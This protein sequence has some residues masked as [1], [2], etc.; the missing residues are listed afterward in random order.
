MPK[1]GAEALATKLNA[2]K[3]VGSA[4]ITA[5]CTVRDD[6]K[7][8]AD[9]KEKLQDC[10]L[11]NINN[12]IKDQLNCIIGPIKF[13]VMLKSVSATM[14]AAMGPMKT[15][16]TTAMP[17]ADQPGFIKTSVDGVE[18]VQK[19]TSGINGMLS[20]N[21]LNLL[22]AG[23]MAIFSL[24]F[25]LFVFG[26]LGIIINIKFKNKLTRFFTFHL[27][28]IV[29]WIV[30]LVA[31]ILAIVFFMVGVL[32]ADLCE[33]IRDSRMNKSDFDKYLMFAL[34]GDMETTIKPIFHTCLLGNG[35][36]VQGLSASVRSNIVN[37]T[38]KMDPLKKLV[39]NV[40]TIWA[41]SA[42]KCPS[43]G[44]TMMDSS[45]GWLSK[46]TTSFKKENT[47]LITLLKGQGGSRDSG[48]KVSNDMFGYTINNFPEH[49][50]IIY[51]SVTAHF[52]S[53]CKKTGEANTNATDTLN[54]HVIVPLK[55][56]CDHADIVDA[57]V[58]GSS[59]VTVKELNATNITAIAYATK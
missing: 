11:T 36:L 38:K 2:T 52:N 12:N 28:W 7:D 39:D 46:Y 32:G 44:W 5:T 50:A 27:G 25:L 1:A 34:K 41:E 17:A 8:D 22:T 26:L 16:I 20:G 42:S 30:N 49:A 3:A 45:T 31:W 13:I 14:S 19:S 35:N 9:L 15:T 18:G 21:M 47:D 40:D 58:L 59:S 37:I 57:N 55:K 43:G 23:F 24:T 6:L 4:D 33:I 54:I 53:I 56:D 10:V 51:K 48:T 29:G